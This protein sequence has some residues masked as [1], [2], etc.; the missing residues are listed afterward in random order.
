MN[1]LAACS[2]PDSPV[3]KVVFKSSAH[4]YG[5]EQDDPA[6]FTEEMRRRHAAADPD[7]A[8]HRRGRGGRRATSPS[9]SPSVDGHRAALRQR[10]RPGPA[11]VA[12]P[13]VRRCRPSRRSSAS[14]RASSSSTRTTSSAASSTRSATTSPGVFNC[15]ADGVLALSEVAGLLGKPFAPVLPPW[16]TGLAAAL[17]RARDP[18]PAGDAPAAALRPRR[19]TT[20]ASRPPASA[21]ASRPARRSCGSRE[22]QRLAADAARRAARAATAT[23]ARSRSSCAGAPASRPSAAPRGPAPSRATPAPAEAGSTPALDDLEAHEIVALLPSLDRGRPAGAAR[24]RGRQPRSPGGDR[25]DR[26]V[27]PAGKTAA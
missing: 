27:A 5:C 20:A 23:S 9:A 1:V 25:R 2:G 13:A 24:A 12:Q 18:P 3:R 26:A 16:G 15:A 10:A 19:S 11:H 6:F 21:T 4:Y 14:T 17:R 8:R 7:R 22:H